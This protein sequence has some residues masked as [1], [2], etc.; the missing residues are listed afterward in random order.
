MQALKQHTYAILRKSERYFKTDMVYLAKG[1]FWLTLGQIATA[2]ASFLL[3]I[4]FANLVPKM[5]YGNFR[6]IT[7]IA[8]SISALSLTGLG[9]AMVPSVA[10]GNEGVL[11]TS[12]WVNIRWSVLLVVVAFAGS[13]YYYINE[14]FVL[15]VSL[16]LIGSFSPLL[17]SF[18]LATYFVNGKKDFRQLSTYNIIKGVAPATVLIGT[19]YLTEHILWIVFVYFASNLFAA[20]VVYYDTI[21]RYR[22]NNIDDTNLLEYGKKLS[23]LNV[24]G[25]IT[26]QLDKILIFTHIGAVELAIYSV[27]IAFPE[28][29]KALF[30]NMN[31][32]II[33]KFA[34]KDASTKE[35]HLKDKLAKLTLLLVA[36]IILY[37]ITA[38]LLF[39]L[40]FPKYGEAVTISQIYSVS[41][42]VSLAWIPTAVLT[43]HAK[44]TELFKM[45]TAISLAQIAIL[46]A[47][48][49]TFGLMGVV[50][51]K[52]V[53]SLVSVI[54]NF[55]YIRKDYTLL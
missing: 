52:I 39:E 48:A 49:Y 3:S 31:M 50:I 20:F 54:I 30:R 23:A 51:A 6:Y 9:T 25:M 27:A 26:A 28:Q 13:A 37:V 42:I 40:F 2:G 19:I 7:S 1:G 5:V 38:P 18:N 16:L 34:E 55:A 36:I 41:I 12:F 45:N 24:L 29:I 10:R 15:S 21:K 22:P 53:N 44:G 32:L 47:G 46:F 33:P 17:N 11:R 43:A 14:N 8:A 4:A 35:L